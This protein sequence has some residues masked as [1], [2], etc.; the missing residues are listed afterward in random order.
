MYCMH[1]HMDK[2]CE[3]ER[4]EFIVVVDICTVCI[5]AY[6]YIYRGINNFMCMSVCLLLSTFI[7]IKNGAQ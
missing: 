1:V 6:A 4:D 2:F 5:C 3:V 7:W